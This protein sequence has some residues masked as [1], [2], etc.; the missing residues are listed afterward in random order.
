MRMHRAVS[1][2]AVVSVMLVACAV[3]PP[4]EEEASDAEAVF[5]EQ[6]REAH[7]ELDYGA[8]G[9]PLLSEETQL[10][11]AGSYRELRRR[12]RRGE[13]PGQGHYLPHLGPAPGAA[14]TPPRRIGRSFQARPGYNV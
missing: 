10:E 11:M 5:L 14:G 4:P 9:Y 12:H 1:A 3:L 7:P 2:V 8:N 6:L 13:H